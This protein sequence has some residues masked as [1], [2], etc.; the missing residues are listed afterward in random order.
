MSLEGYSTDKNKQAGLAL[1]MV[2][3]TVALLSIIVVELAYSTN[4][5]AR[6]HVML[7]RGVKAEYLLKS[8]VNLA[9]TLIKDDVASKAGAREPWELFSK[10]VEIPRSI[11]NVEDKSVTLSLEIRPEEAKIPLKR[12]R[13][14]A[15]TG[16][17]DALQLKWRD[18][19]V[20]LF[21]RLGF[22]EDG[23]EEQSV[24]F[25]GRKFNA[26]EMVANLIDYQDTDSDSYSANN[27]PRGFEGDSDYA[28]KISKNEFIGSIEELS[29][30]PGFTAAR[31]RKMMPYVTV[32]GAGQVVNINIASEAVLLS[33]HTDIG[34]DQVKSIIAFREGAEGPF[35][36]QNR[37][38]KMTDI[39]GG[40]AYG[41]ISSLIS[42]GSSWFQV[43]AKADY[44]NSSN[45][46]RAY[47]QKEGSGTLPTIRLIEIF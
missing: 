45:F 44:G 37:T 12:L 40:Q 13:P 9:R 18:V 31:I 22:D 16:S 30:I 43:I 34:E 33:L 14:I 17:T 4:L 2:L 15:G 27:F 26:Q 42:V 25:K 38:E 28:K 19:L 29:A 20:R 7:T 41:D 11:L 5:R 24:E 3:F 36:D 35:N 32:Y 6:G 23:E 1:I 46:I 10:G 47:L 21:Q 39:V 8:A